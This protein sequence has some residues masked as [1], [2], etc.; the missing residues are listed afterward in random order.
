LFYH[1]E[2]AAWYSVLQNSPRINDFSFSPAAG[3]LSPFKVPEKLHQMLISKYGEDSKVIRTVVDGDCDDHDKMLAY[4]D[5]LDTRRGQDWKQVF[6]E[7]SDC[8]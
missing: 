7:I 6:P 8:F 1:D 4:L 2:F 3:I 5:E